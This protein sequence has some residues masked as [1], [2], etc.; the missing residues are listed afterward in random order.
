ATGS[1]DI[2]EIIEHY[3][4]PR[5]GFASRNFY[6]QFLAVLEVERNAA[7]YFGPLSLDRAP[8]FAELKMPAFME[9]AVVA[10]TL[11]VSLD[12]LKRV[13]PAL[14]PLVWNGSKRIPRD[15][16]LKVDRADFGGNLV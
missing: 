9:A 1:S 10:D 5:F 12:A 13:N 7:Q 4:G 15:Y 6:P 16:T 14:Q 8:D 2:G 11:G 3:K